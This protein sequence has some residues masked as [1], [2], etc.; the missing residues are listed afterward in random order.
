LGGIGVGSG[1]GFGGLSAVTE[2]TPKKLGKTNVKAKNKRV[3]E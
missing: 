3:S 2:L 1:V